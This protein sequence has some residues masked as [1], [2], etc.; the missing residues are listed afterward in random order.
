M[1]GASGPVCGASAPRPGIA[2][3]VSPTETGIAT[4]MNTVVRMIGG[5]V[6]V[7]VFDGLALPEQLAVL[8][9]VGRALLLR[10]V[11]RR[12][13]LRRQRDHVRPR[14]DGVRDWRELL[15][16]GEGAV[17]YLLKDRVSDVTEF[18]DGVRRVAAGGNRVGRGRTGEQRR[19]F[20][21][22]P[23]L[24]NAEFLRYGSIHRNT[25]LT[26]PTR[27]APRQQNG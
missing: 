26:F 16:S 6:G 8:N 19:I 17:G 14:R 3:A 2:D 20:R 9:E 22:I 21:M 5:V 24:A 23:G 1:R 10:G 11:R 13:D 18:V 25:Y 12:W 27:L 15:A 7:A 4:G